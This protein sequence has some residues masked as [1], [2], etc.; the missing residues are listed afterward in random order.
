MV[1]Y[2]TIE[3]QFFTITDSKWLDLLNNKLINQEIPAKC[4]S[5]TIRTIQSSVKLI[6]NGIKNIPTNKTAKNESSSRVHSILKLNSIYYFDIA[7]AEKFEDDDIPFIN[8]AYQ[9]VLEIFHNIK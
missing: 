2:G 9:P 1:K 7:G 3:I 5:K 8:K 6:E 4:S